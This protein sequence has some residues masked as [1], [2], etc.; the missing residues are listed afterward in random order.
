MYVLKKISPSGSGDRLLL[1]IIAPDGESETVRVSPETYRRFGLKKGELSEEQ[2]SEIV[3]TSSYEEALA[4]GIRILGYG[5]N[6]PRQLKDK[7]SRSGVSRETAEACV[8]EIC[9]RGYINESYDAQR[10]AE[11][12]IKKGYGPKRVLA[13][14]RSKGYSD[15]AVDAVLEVFEATDFEKACTRV[16]RV[17]FK[18]LSNERSEVHLPLQIRA[19][20]TSWLSCVP[21]QSN[22]IR[23]QRDW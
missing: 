10:L 6:S 23:F 1:L 15:E 7:L 17:K 2:Y 22:R 3:S 9:A 4:K 20:P 11:S 21:R 14:L 12:L 8:D 18:R 16:A 19:L 5:A 13:S